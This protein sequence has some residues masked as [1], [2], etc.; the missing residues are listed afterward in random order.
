MLHASAAYILSPSKACTD[1]ADLV[2]APGVLRGAPSFTFPCGFTS[3]FLWSSLLPNAHDTAHGDAPQPLLSFGPW[4]E[5]RTGW[6]A[7]QI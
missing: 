1:E 6:F 4:R 2:A 3:C 5:L 7:M